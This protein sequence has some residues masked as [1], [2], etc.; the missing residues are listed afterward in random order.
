MSVK[1]KIR[2]ADPR[3]YQIKKK[4]SGKIHR[5]REKDRRKMRG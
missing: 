4:E 1:E 3:V 5:S 2:A